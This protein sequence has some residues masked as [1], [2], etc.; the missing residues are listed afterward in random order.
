MNS[1]H[2]VSCCLCVTKQRQAL[3]G[4]LRK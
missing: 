3:A 2:A 4:A 1:E